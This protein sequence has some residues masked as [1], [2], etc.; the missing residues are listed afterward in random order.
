MTDPSFAEAVKRAEA[1]IEEALR[2]G[3][4]VQSATK[5]ALKVGDIRTAQRF[6]RIVWNNHTF[7]AALMYKM[8]TQGKN[9]P[10]EE[11]DD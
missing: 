11:E 3:R 9:E 10:D 6:E 5:G 1:A 4:S 7:A 8:E 2:I